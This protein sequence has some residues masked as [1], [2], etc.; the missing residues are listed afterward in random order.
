MQTLVIPLVPEFP[1][2]LS[3]SAPNASWIVTVTLLAGAVFTPISGKLGDI[4]GKKRVA[5]FLLAAIVTGSLLA[6][7]TTTLLPLIIGRALQ[8]AGLG[9]IPL[10]ISMLRDTMPPERLGRSV[11][12]MSSTLGVGAAAGMPLSAIVSQHFDWHMLF[13]ISAGLSAAGFVALWIVVPTSPQHRGLRFD[14]AGAIGLTI[15]FTAL[16]LAISKGSEW[17]WASAPIII[18][19]VGGLAVLAVWGVFQWRSNSPLVDLRVSARRPVLL[20]NLASVAVGFGLFTSPVVLPKLL[21]MPTST[22]V[23]LGQSMLITGLCM[24]PTGLV[25]MATSPVAARISTKY[26]PRICLIVGA[27]TIVVGYGLALILMSEVWH[28]V[29]VGCFSGVGIGFAYAAMPTLIMQSVPE[30]ETAAA[31]GLNTLMRSV[32]TSTA[33]A[34]ITVL[35]AQNVAVVN[36]HAYTTATGFRLAF[37]AAT[38]AAI[39]ALVLAC[40]IPRRAKTYADAIFDPTKSKS[41]V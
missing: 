7:V 11:A 23:G 22:G 8:G 36:G 24:T 28:T 12:L 26:G 41:T 2:L 18:C 9:V 20:T 19:S 15:G 31:N 16:L 34:V 21:E 13:W 29:L 10:G 4:Y 32:G 39:V 25:M 1:K 35:L 27:A 40:F 17:G 14:V 38:L 6:A 5:L 33:S 3:T 37:A 30:S